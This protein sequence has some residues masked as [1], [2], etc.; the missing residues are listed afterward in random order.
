MLRILYHDV[1]HVDLTA[2][3]ASD[4]PSAPAVLQGALLPGKE[5]RRFH[6]L[7]SGW[8]R[9]NGPKQ[10]SRH[11]ARPRRDVALRAIEFGTLE[12]GVVGFLFV[13]DVENRT[14]IGIKGYELQHLPLVDLADINVVVEV[15]RP[16]RLGRDLLVLEAGLGKNQRLRTNGNRQLFE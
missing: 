9:M 14:L 4:V 7:R 11:I 8:V 10:H 13:Q 16:R 1:S 15:K 5:R 6:R 12:D 3:R 2:M